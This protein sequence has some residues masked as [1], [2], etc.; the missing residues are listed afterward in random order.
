M[1][2]K[3]NVSKQR[4]E[5][6]C[7]YPMH[8][9]KTCGKPLYDNERCIFHSK[10]IERKKD[11]FNDDF[12]KE[13][14]SQKEREGPF[15]FSGFVFPDGFSFEKAVFGKRVDFRKAS[16][17]KAIFNDT[18]F[19]GVDFQGANLTGSKFA[20]VDLWGANF[21]KT[22]LQDA[23]FLGR[24]NLKDAHFD[25]ANLQRT[26]FHTT[27][28]MGA[29]F[30][31]AILKK[32]NL[33]HADLQNADFRVADLRG[34]DLTFA[35]LTDANLNSADL[36]GAT[37]RGTNFERCRIADIKYDRTGIYMGIGL[38]NC[39]GSPLFV[40]FAKDQ[41]YLEDFKV[42]Y[43]KTYKAWLIL[44]DCGRSFYLWA[45][46]CLVIPIVFA[47]IYYYGFYKDDL[48]SFHTVYV[49]EQYPCLSFLYYSIVTFTTLGFGDIVPNT[50]WLQF[51]VA[52]EVIL[53]YIML[54]GL[55]SIFANKLA[56]RS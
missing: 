31:K 49:S 40:R 44:A 8:D 27:Y 19:S 11:K 16:L 42:K 7:I 22:N 41:E 39:Y 52:F 6:T 21:A 56:R 30:R 20:E 35:K 34:A 47:L 3:K 28:L 15:D 23:L 55:I 50:G 37:L 25:E 32:A 38:S 9:G 51:L 13:F 46:W 33:Q 2:G 54:G 48:L 53:G 1:T 10:D 17:K 26:D 29:I 14:K 5:R 45:L 18:M 12:K 43:P 4:E 36:R 24:V